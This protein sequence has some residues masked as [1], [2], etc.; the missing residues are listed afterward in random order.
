MISNIYILTFILLL[1]LNSICFSQS[2]ASDRQEIAC[3]LSDAERSARK[4]LVLTKLK[5]SILEKQEL[6]SGYAFRFPG[7]DQML[8]E[9]TSFIKSERKCCSFFVFGLFVNNNENE[10]WLKLTGPEGTKEFI[11]ANLGW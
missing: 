7:N 8:D 9:L 5:K 10:I 4:E 1:G 3:N 2:E 11:N 6:D